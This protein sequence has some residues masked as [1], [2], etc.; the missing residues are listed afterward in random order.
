M[1]IAITG[2]TGFLGTTLVAAL[3]RQGGHVLVTL[4]TA[5]C[6]LTDANA[7]R[8]F[9]H[10]RYDRIYHL[11]AWTRAGDFC[12]RHPGEQW[13]INQ[14]INTNVLAWWRDQQ[15]QA[16]LIAVGTA[17]SY[18][19]RLPLIEEN[20]LIGQPIES[21]FTY[22][23]TKRMLYAGLLALRAQFGLHYLHVVPS[24]LYG[25]GYHQDGREMHFIFD[26]IRK[27]L[28]AKRGGDEVVL[29]GD[30]HQRRELIHVGDFTRIL[31][32]LAD[33]VE[34]ET[35]NIGAGYDHSIREFAGMICA[36]VGYDAEGIRYD[37]SRYT[38]ARSRLLSIE[39][40]RRLVPTVQF[41]PL[42]EGLRQTITW[43]EQDTDLLS[44]ASGTP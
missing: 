42:E 12:L 36:L 30:G 24:M 26:L 8:G 39:K 9:P 14:Q 16:T 13:I 29:W 20:Y 44:P 22:A 15:P 41:T 25:P 43:M 2:A 10:P 27:I 21:L 37:E 33:T 7:L 28:R 34:G 40:L 11:A 6:D 4:S 32:A 1:K 5:N 19:E 3:E 23:M 18:D 31:L 17:G 35:V 38:E